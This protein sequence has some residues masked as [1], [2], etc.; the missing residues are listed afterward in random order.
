M[1]P[2]LGNYNHKNPLLENIIAAITLIYEDLAKKEL[3]TRC[4]DGFTQNNNENFNALV[5][6]FVPKTTLGEAK[7]VQLATY[8][9]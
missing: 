7:V 6:K 8:L 4:L 9:A 2:T 5:W 3:L 1:V